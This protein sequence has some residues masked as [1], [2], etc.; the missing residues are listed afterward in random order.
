MYLNANAEKKFR[1]AEWLISA[2]LREF[3]HLQRYAYARQDLS[4]N[5]HQPLRST[6]ALLFWYLTT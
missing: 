5:A 1:L 4:S 2:I 3:N 6:H